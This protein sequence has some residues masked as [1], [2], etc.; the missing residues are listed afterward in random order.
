[1]FLREIQYIFFASSR[2]RDRTESNKEHG[3]PTRYHERNYTKSAGVTE[4]ECDRKWLPGT[5]TK[6][7]V[8]YIVHPGT[9]VGIYTCI[10]VCI[11][12][13]VERCIEV[14]A[15]VCRHPP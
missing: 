3:A 10:G 9:L 14:R 1:M 6:K 5:V 12:M 15:L 4:C 7:N 11:Y 13:L 2:R 8:C